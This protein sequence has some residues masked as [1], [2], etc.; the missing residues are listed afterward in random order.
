MV[1]PFYVRQSA[2]P[3]TDAERQQWFKDAMREAKDRGAKHA[4]FSIHP[5][6]GWVLIE[7]W[8]IERP[9]LAGGEGNPRWL[10]SAP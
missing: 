5:T 4:R 3:Q 1:E 9:D 8:D 2:E 7:A 10:V 6:Y